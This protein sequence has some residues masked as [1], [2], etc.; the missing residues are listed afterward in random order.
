PPL[1]IR[2]VPIV[3]GANG[4]TTAPLSTADFPDY[5]RT[6]KSVHPLG[7]VS[8][9]V[10]PSFVTSANFGAP[11]SGGDVS[12]W[13]GLISQLDLARIADPTEA[14]ANWF[15]VVLPP[16]GFNFTSTGGFSYIPSNGSATGPNT[17]T[18]SAVGPRWFSRP[19]QARDL[20]AHEIGHSFGRLHAPCGGA[21]APLDPVYPIPGGLIDATGFD[22]FAWANGLASSA[23]AVSTNTGDVMGY[24][25]PVWASTY[26]YKAVLD[27][28]QPAVLAARGAAAPAPRQRVLVVRGSITN[29]D[30]IAI[31]PAF[32]LDARPTSVNASAP[33][34]VPGLAA[35][36]RVLFIA[37]FEP[38]VI[39]H[40][41][42]VRHFTVAVPASAELESSLTSIII[43]TP[44]GQ[45]A[46]RRP[47]GLAAGA[48]PIRATAVRRPAG[49]GVD[50]AC[51]G[52][53]T[54]L[55]VLDA[56]GTVRGVAS[57][58]SAFLPAEAAGSITILCSD[59]V[60]TT[61]LP[62][63]VPTAR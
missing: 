26:T 28:R 62:G 44:F 8:A 50:V 61:R 55:V 11:P 60:R 31:E 29:G 58:P 14:D 16:P 48:A 53:S 3:L 15:G 56:T 2:F 59:G 42:A 41:P 52:A 46:R 39:D 49:G 12:F 54:G 19:T 43:T 17:R 9:H 35:D 40:A 22:V 13:I 36:G 20:V 51:T 30:T 5:L 37:G 6:L 38:A 10:G 34:R 25:F 7:A 1:T 47:A 57:A 27:F 45:A 63:V 32:T 21:G 23:P 33:Y 4:G 18:S 24:C